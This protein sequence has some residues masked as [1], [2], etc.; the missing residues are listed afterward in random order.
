M[1]ECGCYKGVDPD[2]RCSPDQSH[3]WRCTEINTWQFVH[4]CSNVG[5]CKRPNWFANCVKKPAKR[6]I[7]AVDAVDAVNYIDGVAFQDSAA[8]PCS[9]QGAYRC[10]PPDQLDI[11]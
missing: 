2:E 3:I 4:N 1:G 8:I 11:W 7:N 6:D 5:M 10:A 9:Q